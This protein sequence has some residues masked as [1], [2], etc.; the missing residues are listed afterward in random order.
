MPASTGLYLPATLSSAT[1]PGSW[2][3]MA[4]RALTLWPREAAQLCAVHGGLWITLDG[5]PP[6]LPHGLGDH[7]LPAGESFTVPAGRRA[8]IEPWGVAPGAHTYF[9]WDFVA[10]RRSPSAPPASRL[11]LNLLQP[12]A[13]LRAGFRAFSAAVSAS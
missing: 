9:S 1:L 8:V 3:L 12:L 6:G 7:F 10:A 11:P 4:G 13:D 5:Q 2:K